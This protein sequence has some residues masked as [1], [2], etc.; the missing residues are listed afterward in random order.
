[1]K[2]TDSLSRR[3]YCIVCKMIRMDTDPTGITCGR[4]ECL[5]KLGNKIEELDELAT[6]KMELDWIGEMVLDIARALH[7]EIKNPENVPEICQKINSYFWKDLEIAPE[8]SIS[9]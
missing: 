8:H 7:L 3:G 1:M 2:V 9:Q 5:E 6:L 4:L